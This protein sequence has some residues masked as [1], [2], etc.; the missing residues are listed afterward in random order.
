MSGKEVH[1]RSPMSSSLAMPSVLLV[2]R[3]FSPPRPGEQ[4]VGGHR[5][6]RAEVNVFVLPSAR[7]VGR[8]EDEQER[9]RVPSDSV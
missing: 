1:P 3:P 6:F 9:W 5:L 8:Q 7:D 2:S 4:P